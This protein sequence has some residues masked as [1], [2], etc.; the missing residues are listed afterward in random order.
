[1]KK[2]QLLIGGEW[3]NGA[4][5]ISVD[6]PYD[7][8]IVAEVSSG[9]EDD[10]KLAVDKAVQG[11]EKTRRLSSADRSQILGRITMGIANRLEEFAET[12]ALEAGKPIKDARGEVSRAVNTFSIASEESKRFG[13]EVI[14]LDTIPPTAGRWGFTR[15]FP[16]GPTLAISPFN[17]PLNLV[18]HKVAPAIAVGNP[19]IVK[20]SS[21]APFTALKLGEVILESG[22]PEEAVSVIPCRGAAAEKILRDF[23]LKKLTFTGSPKVGWRLKSLCGRMK[24]TLELGGNAAVIV[25]DPGT[26]DYAVERCI[27]GA[28]SY[29]GQI[30]ISIQRI[31]LQEDI[32]DRFLAAFLEE[33]KALKPGN[34]LDEE[35][36]LGPMIDLASAEKA[37]SWVKSA[38][39]AGA[40]MLLGGEREGRMFPATALAG[41]PR[42]QPAYSSE[43]FAPVVVVSKY[44]EFEDALAEVN[45][46]DYGLQAGVF[47]SDL[48]KAWRAFETLEVGGVIVGDIPTFRV[49]HMPYGG[50]KN[51]GFGREGVRYAMEEMSELRLMTINPVG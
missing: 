45:D 24:V 7:G 51:S 33:A 12:I 48:N 34:P 17:F 29:A 44:R 49:D 37:E 26:L 6:N 41:V 22:W 25:D 16:V 46:S 13:G 5:T 20:P 18:A 23:R 9:G 19:V 4:G 39:E 36:R 47:T 28:Y 8:S 21:S 2:Y 3:I 30:C 42:S 35:T 40:E 14:P 11:F 43:I 38:V 27:T 1:M 31:I 32:Y 15:R 50:V 10:L